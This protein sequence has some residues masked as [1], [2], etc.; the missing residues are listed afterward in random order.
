MHDAGAGDFA[1]VGAIGGLERGEIGLGGG[2]HREGD[3]SHFVFGL[4]APFDLDRRT[5]RVLGIRVRVIPA[6]FSIELG[7]LGERDSVFEEVAILPG[8]VPVFDIEESFDG[9]IWEGGGHL[10][11][12]ADVVGV[13]ADADGFDVDGEGEGVAD[14]EIFLARGDVKRGEEA[15]GDGELDGGEGVRGG[16]FGEVEADGGLFGLFLTDGVE[17]VLEHE[18]GS[19][20]EFEG[21]AVGEEM[22]LCADGDAP[23]GDHVAGDFHAGGGGVV[24]VFLGFDAL[25]VGGGIG[26]VEDVVDDLA[27]GGAEFD[28]A[29]PLV[30]GEV[31]RNAEVAVD[32]G[33][34]GGDGEGFVHFDDEV[35]SAELPAVGEVG[36][37]WSFGGVA[38]GHALFD[39]VLEGFDL[40]VGEAA[41][42]LIKIGGRLGFPGRHNAG[43]GDGGDKFGVFGGVVVIEEGK[44]GSFAGA[45]ATGA[46]GKE[47]GGN[48]L[49]EGDGR[50]QGGRG[51]GEEETDAEI[52]V[53]GEYHDFGLIWNETGPDRNQGST[54][55]QISNR[56]NCPTQDEHETVFVSN[57]R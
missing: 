19:F 44:G 17:V 31:E 1:D 25:G 49:A 5:G 45:V 36:E 12:F 48:V 7:A 53:S 35:G 40:V 54:N 57:T 34:V 55:L 2:I 29:D 56:E 6:Y 15:V 11:G 30:V 20:G 27:G 46:V 47:D 41:R 51:A 28:G 3:S 14:S 26:E 13:C 33:A 37:G 10:H 32:V 22:R 18:V 42:V 21:E 43:G 23:E 8:E 39:P 24:G 38:L 9:A 16:F 52:E 50:G 4:F